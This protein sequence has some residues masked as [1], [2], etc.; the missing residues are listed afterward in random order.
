M[1]FYSQLGKMIYFRRSKTGRGRRPQ[2]RTSPSLAPTRFTSPLCVN[3]ALCLNF[4]FA[5]GLSRPSDRDQIVLDLYWRSPESCDFWYKPRQSG[6]TICFRRSK[7]ARGRRHQSRTSPILAP[8]R[9]TPPLFV[10]FALCVHFLFSSR[11]RARSIILFRCL[12]CT[13][14]RR[15][16]ATFGRD[17][18]NWE[19]RF[20]LDLFSTV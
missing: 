7:T 3:F 18:G 14:A 20:V 2:S 13:G 16:P 9:F 1:T 15:N 10:N 19:R 5:S 12:I 17:Q 6:N 8:T 4:C 11:L